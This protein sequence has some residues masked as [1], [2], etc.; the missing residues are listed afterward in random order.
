MIASLV[1]AVFAA[2]LGREEI[3]ARFKA[4][5]ATRNNGLL[6]V[7]AECPADMRLDYQVPVARL[8]SGVCDSLY[9]H[10]CIEQRR[11][12]WPRIAIHI[13]PGRT[14]DTTV[15][16][17]VGARADGSPV[18]DIRLPSPGFSDVGK[19]RIEVARAF[20]LALR[21][22]RIDAAAAA[23]L[24]RDADPE[25]RTRF[26]YGEIDKWLRGQSVEGDDEEMLKLCRTVLVPGA[27]TPG[28]V[29]RFASRL[30]LYPLAYD[31]PFCGKYDCCSVA[32]AVKLWRE[33]PM[34][35]VAALAKASQIVVF[36]GGRGK[37]LADAAEAYSRLL[38]AI[39]AGKTDQDALEDM[40][41]DA[42]V[43]LNIAFEHAMEG[44]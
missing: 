14:N 30:F 17:S 3:V 25:E 6:S 5:V 39:A 16:T 11:F 13:C 44:D 38:F 35:R 43:K 10:L 37:H 20:M 15:A 2:V 42:D 33:D 31:T 32:Q 29:L 12:E 18:T 9:R 23:R 34:I 22:E 40:L 19:L 21:G 4:P 1:C 28:D 41:E 8:A 7:Y 36:G 26:Q 24:L 27:A